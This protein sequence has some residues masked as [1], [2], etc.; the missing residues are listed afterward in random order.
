MAIRK[1][2]KNKKRVSK[3]KK[4]SSKTK[5]RLS[6]TKKRLSKSNKKRLSKSIKKRLSKSNKNNKN[7][8]NNQR[9]GFFGSSNCSIASVKEPGFNL[10]SLGS[11]ATQ[12]TGFSIPDQKAIIFDPQCKFDTNHAMVP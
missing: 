12:I 5:Q 6:K 11:G 3:T 8:K 9:G 2:S 10:P 1:L 4:R 7:N